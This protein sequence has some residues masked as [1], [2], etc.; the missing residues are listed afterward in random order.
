MT[1]DVSVIIPTLN[2]EKYLAPCLE[3]L[4]RQE[5][6]GSYEIVVGDGCS[7]DATEAICRDYGAKFL[8]EPKPTIAAG[9]QKACDA[10][11]GRTI[12]STDADIQAPV[13][14]LDSIVSRFDG[15]VGLY[16]NIVPYDGS[17]T[18]AWMCR[19]VMSRYMHVMD[20]LGNPVPAGSNLAF[21]RSAFEEVGGFN[22]DLVTAEDLDLTKKLM[23]VGK[24]AYNPHGHVYVSLRRVKGW[25]YG[26]YVK[27]HVTNA[28]K[29]H[30]TGK[31]HDSYEPV[32]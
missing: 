7:T 1:M 21:K 11:K 9:R 17:R 29:Y 4:S 10:A 13:N 18:E 5:F 3:S 19:N 26:N 28:I 31:S 23:G 25:G 16:G 15:N 30:A 2:E 12:V 20:C 8:V 22:T 6:G 32:R 14:W 24:V 27:F